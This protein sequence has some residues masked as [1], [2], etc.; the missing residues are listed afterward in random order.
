M[1]ER[2]EGVLGCL[3]LET[4]QLRA[5]QPEERQRRP[6]C[7]CCRHLVRR[8]PGAHVNSCP[9]HTAC[10][11]AQQTATAALGKCRLPTP[12]LAQA[13]ALALAARE[14]GS[15]ELSLGVWM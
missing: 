9:T 15:A 10:Q 11:D 14:V 2:G 6:P 5:E 1:R 3:G 8:R 4:P 13:P 12:A 7:C